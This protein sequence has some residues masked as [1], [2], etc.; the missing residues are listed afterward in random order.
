MR[1]PGRRETTR[2][3]LLGY[4]LFVSEDVRFAQGLETCFARYGYSMES[5]PDSIEAEAM[6]SRQTPALVLLDRRLT[7][8]HLF[9]QAAPLRTIPMMTVVPAGLEWTEEVCVD[10]LDRGMDSTHVCDENFRLLVAKARALL[11][12]SSWLT[13]TATV[14]RA[15][16]VELDIDR[17]EVR[18]AGQATHLPPL[19]FKLLKCLMESPGTLFRRQKLLDYIWGE[20]YAVE[21]HTLDVHIFWLRRLLERDPAQRQRI[22]TIRGIGVKFVLSSASSEVTRIGGAWMN[23]TT[24][25]RSSAPQRRTQPQ[26]AGRT[27]CRRALSEL[28]E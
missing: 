16:Q 21:A 6:A 13:K 19:Q 4:L 3:P 14:A 5:V 1:H 18:V 24:N 20:G 28:M 23:Q 27:T 7:D 2:I 25:R 15:G 9:R 12:R 11:R 22:A 10:D 17:H 26:R 8:W